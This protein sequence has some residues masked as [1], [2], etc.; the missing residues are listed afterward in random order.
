MTQP[1]SIHDDYILE[2]MSLVTGLI[3]IKLKI[4]SFN[5]NGLIFVG[6]VILCISD[7]VYRE[8]V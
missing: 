2:M 4:D 7:S 5:S 3:H 6:C 8:F 1:H